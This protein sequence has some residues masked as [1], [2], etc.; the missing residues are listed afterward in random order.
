MKSYMKFLTL[1]NS[2]KV[3]GNFENGESSVTL[4]V[5]GVGPLQLLL[6][7]LEVRERLA[8]LLMGSNG[9]LF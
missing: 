5:F 8:I 1:I 9:S 7:T 6:F 2:E 3:K 4:M